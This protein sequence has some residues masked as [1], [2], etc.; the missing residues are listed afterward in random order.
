VDEPVPEDTSTD[1]SREVPSADFLQTVRGMVRDEPVAQ[2][3]A[4]ARPGARRAD[5]SLRRHEEKLA[6]AERRN[7]RK[8][9]KRAR[10]PQVAP[11]LEQPAEQ[12][13]GPSAEQPPEV[14]RVPAQA[15]ETVVEGV[16]ELDV[17]AAVAEGRAG[18]SRRAGRR[19]HRR[20][21]AVAAAG[22]TE[23]DP[24]LVLVE[25]SGSVVVGP[26]RPSRASRRAQRRR[27]AARAVAEAVP[28][29]EHAGPGSADETLAAAHI[30][31]VESERLLR[32]PGSSRVRRWVK[33]AAVVVVVAAAIALPWAD[34]RLP[35]AISG[36]LPGHGEH[37]VHVKD[38]VVAPP[39]AAV[40]GPVG[41]DQQG[42]QYAGVRLQAAGW[43][44]QMVVPRL[45]VDSDVVPISGQSG[46]L[47]PPSD[48]Q[49]LGWWREGQPVGAQYGTAV[50]TGHTV[51]TGGGALDN[52]DKLVVGD[53][54][55]VR[56]DDGWIGYVVQQTRIYSTAELARDAEN[57]FR[58]GGTGRLVVI[59]C[60]DWNGEFYE[61]NAV[62]VATPVLDEP[63]AG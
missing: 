32:R 47:L 21:V 12:P 29:A 20:A 36:I 30:G 46:S 27:D 43:P 38:P 16:S 33:V 1:A 56:T 17:S 26:G 8:R 41:L 22:P 49:L 7:A 48:P 2:P 58:L 13:T 11:T 40:V 25:G 19:D 55:R 24:E 3:R 59:T 5:K 61:S 18:L 44:R 23:D 50:V 54:L 60:D 31:Q 35:E 45:H 53:S 42:G 6:K 15:T 14:Q 63:T 10:L 62:V 51:H 4:A 39:T 28:V 57:V 9:R 37:A 52:L 34:P